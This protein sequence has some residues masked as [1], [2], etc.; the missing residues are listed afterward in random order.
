MFI[1]VLAENE[2]LAQYS[3]SGYYDS[4]GWVRFVSTLWDHMS[5]MI[6]TGMIKFAVDWF[7]LQNKK[8]QLEN[9][10]LNAELNYLKA[11]INPHFLFNTL[12]N[13]NYLT[14]AKKDEATNVVIKLSNIMRYMIY[15]SNKSTVPLSAE[16][17]YMRDY[18]DLE[19]IRLNNEFAITFDTDDVDDKIEIA[20]LILIPFL[21]N[22]FKHGVSDK[23]PE[24][25]V[26]LKISSSRNRISML[27]QNSICKKINERI[28]HSG[29]GLK[30]VKKR[31]QLSYPHQHTLNINE[32]ED[33][34]SVE[35]VLNLDK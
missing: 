15:D 26:H 14:Q 23:C 29:F 32:T 34:Y 3:K 10:K 30:N 33:R 12:H 7:E 24:S 19:K 27:L 1:S 20:P 9:E 18:L 28:D 11:Q 6:F 2:I 8:Q 16:I 35:L 4:F 17:D 5:F 31:L 22:S 21:E 13:L 25:W